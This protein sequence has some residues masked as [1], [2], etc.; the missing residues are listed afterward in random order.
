[1]A[2]PSSSRG[3]RSLLLRQQARGRL[4]FLGGFLKAPIPGAARGGLGG[5]VAERKGQ[6]ELEEGEENRPVPPLPL[7]EVRGGGSGLGI[8]LSS[9]GLEQK[10]KDTW[11]ADVLMAKSNFKVKEQFSHIDQTY[12]RCFSP[13]PPQP[14]LPH[15]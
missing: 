7:T 4:H 12:H 15:L 11:G 2:S 5:G 6:K 13:P 3:Q 14:L 1:M 8:N 10:V 9:F